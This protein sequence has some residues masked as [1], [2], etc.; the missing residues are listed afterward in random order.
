[1][2]VV[3]ADYDGTIKDFSKRMHPD[4]VPAIRRWREQ[5]NAFGVATGRDVRMIMRELTL[6]DIPFDFLITLNG[7]AL[8]DRDLNLLG[9]SMLDDTL[10]P[11]LLQHPAALASL[12]YQLLGNEMIRFFRRGDTYF[13]RFGVPFVAVDFEAALAVKNIGQINFYYPTAAEC[14]MWTRLLDADFAGLVK[15]HPNNRIVDLNRP[16]VDKAAAVAEILPLVGLAG[17]PV[18]AV[19]DGGNDLELVREYEGYTV[20]GAAPEVLAVARKVYEN[21]AEMLDDLGQGRGAE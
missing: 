3:V 7:A 13:Q 9:S 18:I 15:C 16:G 6:Y 12:H 1:M 2:R 8:Y 10:I 14:A 20:P 19:G 4:V 21:V 11:D 5:G 17:K